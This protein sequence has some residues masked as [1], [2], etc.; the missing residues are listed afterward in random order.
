METMIINDKSI[1]ERVINKKEE[2]VG[3]TQKMIV[4]DERIVE[5]VFNTKYPSVGSRSE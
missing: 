5:R 3:R 4:V 1:I 2:D